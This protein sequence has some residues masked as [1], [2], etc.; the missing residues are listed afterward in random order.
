[1]T[2]IFNT[3]ILNWHFA[4][5]LTDLVGYDW[6]LVD[7][8]VHEPDDVGP[9]LE[10]EQHGGVAVHEAPLGHNL[11]AHH[12]RHHRHL[13]YEEGKGLTNNPGLKSGP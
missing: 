12:L 3:D 5:R 2:T 11:D 4:L 7:D 8:D 10:V 6:G 1:M 13:Q 9:V